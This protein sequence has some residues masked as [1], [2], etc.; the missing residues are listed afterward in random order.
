MSDTNSV[1]PVCDLHGIKEAVCVHTDKVTDSCL[2]KDCI[3]DLRVYLTLESQRVLDQSTS[4]KARYV[5][6]MHVCIQVEAVPYN[7]G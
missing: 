3:E 1:K 4:A 7:T 5:E 6:L 2:A